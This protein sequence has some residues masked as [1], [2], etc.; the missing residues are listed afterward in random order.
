MAAGSDSPVLEH[1]KNYL[2]G[3]LR[4][5]ARGECAYCHVADYSPREP[6]RCAYRL[7]NGARVLVDELPV[8]LGGVGWRVS[9]GALCLADWAVSHPSLFEGK[10]VLELGSGLGLSGLAAAH[11]GA[12]RVCLTDALPAIVANLE[13]VIEHNGVAGCDVT[14]RLLDWWDG[15]DGAQRCSTHT[16]MEEHLL[17]TQSGDRQDRLLARD[18]RFDVVLAAEVMYESY[19]ARALPR[20][21][22]RRL[23]RDTSAFAYVLQA[24]REDAPL[25]SSSSLFAQLAASACGEGL[26]LTVTAPRASGKAPLSIVFRPDAPT[27][28]GAAWSAAAVAR[29]TGLLMLTFEWA[30]AANIRV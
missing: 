25:A 30:A 26:A 1:P 28:D 21:I 23:R 4:Q 13:R 17:A 12:V 14:A 7:S 8:S 27:P 6:R 2:R 22:A 5:C 20:T 10:S 24:V 16:S 9:V 19:H 3:V 15:C 18:E 11:A 29:K